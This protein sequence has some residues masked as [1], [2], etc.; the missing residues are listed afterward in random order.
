M[1][2]TLNLQHAR[3]DDILLS[4]GCANTLWLAAVLPSSWGRM[5]G[6]KARHV[7][8]LCTLLDMREDSA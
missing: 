4:I 8:V 2:Q 5:A 3:L 1:D 6:K 7:V